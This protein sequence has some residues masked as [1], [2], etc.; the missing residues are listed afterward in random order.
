MRRILTSVFIVLFSLSF[1]GCTQIITEYPNAPSESSSSDEL[2]QPEIT[3]A[4]P[5]EDDQSENETVSEQP[6]SE[7]NSVN[8]TSEPSSAEITSSEPA[9]ADVSES[10]EEINLSIDMPEP[11]GTMQV[12]LEADNKYISIIVSERN[13]DA[14]LL[15]AVYSVPESGQNYVFEFYSSAERSENNIRRVYFINSNEKIESVAASKTTERENISAAENWFSMNVLIK[16]M[17]FPAV[18]DRM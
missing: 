16:K 10:Y 6:S 3:D 8:N 18:K 11:N 1:F 2:S 4:P 9:S 13:I 12:S 7:N 5:S 15:A 17:I 14:A